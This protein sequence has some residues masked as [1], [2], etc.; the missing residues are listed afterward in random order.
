MQ[1][2]VEC[3]IL[4]HF[5]WAFRVC[6]STRFQVSIIIIIIII[7]V[8]VIIIIKFLFYLHHPQQW[9]P[10]LH[11]PIQSPVGTEGW[12]PWRITLL[13][14]LVRTP[15]KKQLDPIASWGR[16]VH[17]LWNMLMTKNIFRTLPSLPLMGFSWPA[18]TLGSWPAACTYLTLI[19]R[20]RGYK[21]FHAQLCWAWNLSCALM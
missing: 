1:T 13:E 18:H 2:V 21:T 6:Q 8:V 4:W 9:A 19:I 15:L 16:S 17:L 5:L 12:T 10:P 11:G 14:I 7:I 20:S 3:C